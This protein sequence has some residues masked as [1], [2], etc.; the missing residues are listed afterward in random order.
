MASQVIY[1]MHTGI[2]FVPT[3]RHD[4][5]DAINSLNADLSGKIILVTGASKGIGR[6]ISI[7]Y[8]QAGASGLALLARNR[9]GLEDTRKACLEAQR[10]NQNLE[11]LLLNTDSA[12]T[13]AVMSALKEVEAT[14]KRLDIVV[15]DAGQFP[16]PGKVGDSD[17]SEWW[18]VWTVNI[19][20]LFNV[21]RAAL[22]L[23]ISSGG[24][25]G[26]KTIVNVGS[27]AALY[28]ESTYSAYQTTKLAI[29]RLSEVIAT[30]YEDKGI[31]C[32]TI[33]PGYIVTDM[34]ADLPEEVKNFLIDTP[35]VAAHTIVFYSKERRDWLAG[36]YLS[37]QRDVE[38][39]LA[40][41]EIVAGD[42][43]KVRM[44]F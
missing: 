32:Y 9:L 1:P 14:L 11:V 43:L 19:K 34:T 35:E 7:A 30:E 40:K 21:T 6:A 3:A 36:R 33:H 2:S 23:L 4:T 8:A 24:D 27:I 16:I 39:L 42:K 17:P 13:E 38:E 10:P 29:L 41:E 25:S 28:V 18:D 22:P 44:A 12:D 26:L 37:S 20:G 15:N 5:Y 31:L